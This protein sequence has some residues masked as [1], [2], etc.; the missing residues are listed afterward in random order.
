[1]GTFTFPFAALTI[2]WA[3]CGEVSAADIGVIDHVQET[4]SQPTN[5]QTLCLTCAR[6]DEPNL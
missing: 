5:T 4:H 6:G 2:P 1:M 3:S